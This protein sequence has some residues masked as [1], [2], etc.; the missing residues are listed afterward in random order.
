MAAAAQR[1]TRS[2]L[3][4]L[5]AHDPGEVRKA[6]VAGALPLEVQV[7]YEEGTAPATPYSIPG[8]TG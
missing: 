8:S 2:G 6:S 7:P 4:L 5:S 1:L 3:F